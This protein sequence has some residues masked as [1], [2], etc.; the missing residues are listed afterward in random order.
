MNPA[1]KEQIKHYDQELADEAKLHKELLKRSNLTLANFSTN[2]S[3]AAES[4]AERVRLKQEVDELIDSILSDSIESR[5]QDKQAQRTGPQT[6]DNN[7]ALIFD[8]I[9]A[10][11]AKI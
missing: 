1:A 6:V 8:E 3:E 10:E 11:D 5:K 7:K 4:K 2:Q 9:I